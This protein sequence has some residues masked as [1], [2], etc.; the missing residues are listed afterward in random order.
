MLSDQQLAEIEERVSEL[1]LESLA[2][3]V[4]VDVPALLT[5]VRALQAI[6]FVRDFFQGGE[7]NELD[8][9][10]GEGDER[11]SDGHVER[12]G[13]AAGGADA[14]AVVPLPANPESD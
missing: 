6:V 1:Y 11:V 14:D 12:E 10:I 5:E 8:G 9:E 7:G 2:Q 13:G 4:N 3:I